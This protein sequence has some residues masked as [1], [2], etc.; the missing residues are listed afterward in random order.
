MTIFILFFYLWVEHNSRPLISVDQSKI[1]AC[2]TCKICAT[3]GLCFK[4]L[5]LLVFKISGT[6]KSENWKNVRKFIC[7]K[8]DFLIVT[9][10]RY[11]SNFDHLK[12]MY[13]SSI[14]FKSFL[15][16]EIPISFQKALLLL[17]W[18]GLAWVGLGWV[19]GRVRSRWFIISNYHTGPKMSMKIYLHFFRF[20]LKVLSLFEW[21]QR[22]T[23]YYIYLLIEAG[24]YPR[25]G[26]SG[27]SP[28]PWA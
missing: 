28:P 3:F 15:G 1:Y 9:L 17:G 14:F 8:I 18:V 26:R 12:I 4:F 24:A 6:Q 16:F 22:L 11:F 7:I 10:G 20:S 21:R 19:V 2:N 27:R 23:N 25:G 13:I 5:T